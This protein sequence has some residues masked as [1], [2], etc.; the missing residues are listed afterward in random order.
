MECEN[1]KNNPYCEGTIK[2]RIKYAK[3]MRVCERCHYKLSK[4]MKEGK[5]GK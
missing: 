3:G 4:E 2:G 1:K 5:E